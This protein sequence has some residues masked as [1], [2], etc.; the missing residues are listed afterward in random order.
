[1]TTPTPYV[2]YA[3]F[4]G[5]LQAM[6]TSVVQ[7]L[8]ASSALQADGTAALTWV[9]LT[10]V[11]DPVLSQAGLLRCRLDLQFVRRGID[12]PA[13]IIAGRAPDR[14]GVAYFMP[15]TDPSTGI[16]LVLAGDR[17]KTVPHPMTNRQPVF[18]TFEIRQIPDMAQDYVG[19][20]HVETQI[21]EVSE[22]LQPGS[23]QPFPGAT[24]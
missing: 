11:V 17:L 21:V 19:A 16:P 4:Q 15:A 8:R 1:M 22:S 6:F 20:H 13:P 5:G 7:V 24:T 12:Q 23:P 9:P 3:P 2:A 14:V 10:I 18:G